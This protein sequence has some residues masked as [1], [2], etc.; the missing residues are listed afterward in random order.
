MA[1]A[2][3]PGHSGGTAARGLGAPPGQQLMPGWPGGL[4]RAEYLGQLEGRQIALDTR[5]RSI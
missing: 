5:N 1:W 2:S 4:G 3:G